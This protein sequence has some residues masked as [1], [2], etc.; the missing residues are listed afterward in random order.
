MP[1]TVIK[2]QQLLTSPDVDAVRAPPPAAATEQPPS[3][4]PCSGRDAAAADSSNSSGGSG[5]SGALP[6]HT[7]RLGPLKLGPGAELR[8]FVA[9]P[10]GA[11][12]A[13]LVVRS[14]AYDTSKTFLLRATALVPDV[15]YTDSEW[16]S[17]LTLSPNA[18]FNA[19]FK[20]SAT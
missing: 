19:S 13:E 16:R 15:R 20:A 5:D 7:L 6:P 2:P 10:A 1:Q 9:V 3:G 14:G 18:E 17:N 11:T 12:W 4:G 8:H